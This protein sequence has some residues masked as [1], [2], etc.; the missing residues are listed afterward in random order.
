MQ[1][2]N[3]STADLQNSV[4]FRL[5]Q[6][7]IPGSDFQP[8]TCTIK[9][10]LHRAYQQDLHAAATVDL[11]PLLLYILTRALLSLHHPGD[12]PSEHEACYHS[13]QQCNAT[14]MP[15]L[16][17]RPASLGQ[18]AN[19]AKTA[20]SFWGPLKE[21]L[22]SSLFVEVAVI[23]MQVCLC[24]SRLATIAICILSHVQL[25]QQPRSR[26]ACLPGTG[27]QMTQEE[28]K[29]KELT[30]ISSAQ[31]RCHVP[32]QRGS[33]GP[34]MSQGVSMAYVVSTQLS[35]SSSGG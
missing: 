17:A 12:F 2:V 33:S 16:W 9:H 18:S 27:S 32:S 35:G 13:H 26:T 20:N 11:E 14:Q 25:N 24:H 4:G 28:E 6:E 30:S 7:S 5:I 29:E 21:A 19:K 34:L 15:E 31:G 8:A 10:L 1:L 22:C 23:T 3:V